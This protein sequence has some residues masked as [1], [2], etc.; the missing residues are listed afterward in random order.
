[1]FIHTCPVVTGKKFG[2]SE[3]GTD[4][5]N[6]ISHATQQRLQNLLEKVSQVAQLKNLNFKVMIIYSNLRACGT[7]WRLQCLIA[8]VAPF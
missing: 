5:I 6:Y 7:L 2:V 1:M 4:V 8:P 3:L